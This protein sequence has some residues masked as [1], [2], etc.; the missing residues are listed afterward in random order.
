MGN[1]EYFE[2]HNVYYSLQE[3]EMFW[4]SLAFCGELRVFIMNST[5]YH[6]QLS[7]LLHLKV[8]L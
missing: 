8:P 1:D 7:A 4:H 2:S 6:S 3:S 5:C